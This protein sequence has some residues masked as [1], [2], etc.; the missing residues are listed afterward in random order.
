MAGV[1]SVSIDGEAIYVF[2][3]AIYIFET[4]SGNTLE[5]D[6]V[7]SE[8]TLRKYKNRESLI[9]EIELEDGRII[10]SFMFLKTLPGK[11]PRLNLLCEL[12]EDEPY[13]DVLRISENDLAFPDIEEGITLEEIR[14]VEMPNEK[15]TLKLNLPID[16]VEWL[17]EKKSKELNQ[18]F[19]EFL[20]EHCSGDLK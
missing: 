20:Y 17:K 1:K 2:N 11:L 12:D 5:V 7:V 3:S 6:M 4:S 18:L 19:K 16:Q 8:V 10:S 15:V 13:E 14:K 9:A